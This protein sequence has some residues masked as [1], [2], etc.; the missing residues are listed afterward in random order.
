MHAI[1]VAKLLGI[2][3]VVVPPHPGIASAYGLLVAE[4]KNDYA[5]TFLQ[6]P[7]DYDVEGMARG[8]RRIGT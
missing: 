2:G 4:F 5:R 6:H 1:D 7:P 8:I 3:T